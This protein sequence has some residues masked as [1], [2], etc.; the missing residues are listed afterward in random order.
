MRNDIIGLAKAASY[1]AAVIEAAL[2][3]AIADSGNFP[4]IE[5]GTRVLIKPNLVMAK[6]PEDAATTHPSIV[7]ALVKY[8]QN[9]GAQV[10]VGDCPGGPASRMYVKRVYETTGM[11]EVCRA[12]EATLA[13]EANEV[14]TPTP[15]GS[16][17]AQ[18]E[19]ADYVVAADVVITVGKCKTHGLT[20]MTGCVKN[21][22]GCIPGVRKV[23]YHHRF[24][25][26]GDFCGMLLA[27]E[28][29]V[30]PAYAILDAVVGM[31]GAGPSGGTPR[32]IGCLVVGANAHAV[33]W[34]ASRLMGYK[35]SDVEL[36]VQA[37]AQGLLGEV[38]VVGD[39]LDPLCIEDYQRQ[40]ARGDTRI[41]HK[42]PKFVR[43]FLR[44]TCFA[45]PGFDKSICT[46]CSECAKC[47]PNDAIVMKNR[48]PHLRPANCIACFCCQELCP[49]TAVKIKRG[50]IK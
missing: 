33:D 37:R 6:K 24:P 10:T 27:L 4:A 23:D 15:E 44:V 22:Y 50:I 19:L 47:C 38:Q 21:L 41:M 7:L 34:V 13:T 32:T 16:K 8:L 43:A 30:K 36:L 14:L 18:V 26:I 25:V 35:E 5:S 48:K 11:A 46:G 28:R 42:A 12:T 39:A 17:P 31:E 49:R 20:A 2:A 3:Q 45:K 1:D 9:L 40:K 29:T